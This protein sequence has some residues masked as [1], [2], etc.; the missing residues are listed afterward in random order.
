MPRRIGV[1]GGTFD[2]VHIGHLV[3][4]SEVR[5]RLRLELVL[6]VVAAEPWQK[7][8]TRPITPAADRLAVVEAAVAGVTGL[9]ASSIEIDRGGP[10][11]TADTLAELR[12]GDPDAEVFLVVGADVA[13]LVHT[14][15]RPDEVRRL[16]TLVVVGRPG[17]ASNAIETLSGQGWRVEEVAIPA[18]EVSS[19]DLRARL[20]EGRP[21]DFLVPDAAIRELERRGRY[22]GSR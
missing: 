16:A 12:A 11:Y 15:E 17:A 13:A 2:P 14:W 5:W 22:S 4:A 6:L 8:G 20:A 1:L 18:L 7:I 10:T 9:Q 3:A 19:T 21:I